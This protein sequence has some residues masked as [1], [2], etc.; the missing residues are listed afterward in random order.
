V[1]QREHVLYPFE[2][3]RLPFSTVIDTSSLCL[4]SKASLIVLGITILP[5]LSIFPLFPTD[6]DLL[7]LNY[8]NIEYLILPGVDAE[9]SKKAK[10]I[11]SKLPVPAY[12][13]AGLHPH[14][15]KNLSHQEK[16]NVKI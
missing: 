3:T 5:R 12:W 9:S 11:S 8:E 15:A 13:A 1:L 14:D 2:I 4:T 6:Y 16:S 10:D 7:S